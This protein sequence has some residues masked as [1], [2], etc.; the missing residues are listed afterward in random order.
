M[1]RTEPGP[2]VELR[3][4][5]E[6]RDFLVYALSGIDE[7]AEMFEFLRGFFPKARFVIQPLR[8]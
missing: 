4:Q 3:V 6:G 7:A 8:H 2:R 5:E 1:N